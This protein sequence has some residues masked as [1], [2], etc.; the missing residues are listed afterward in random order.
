MHTYYKRK[1]YASAVTAALMLS[2]LLLMSGVQAGAADDLE[3]RDLYE[4]P[5][6]PPP[7]VDIAYD[8]L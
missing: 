7:R 8:I 4:P 6:T 1:L 5:G 2:S 3:V